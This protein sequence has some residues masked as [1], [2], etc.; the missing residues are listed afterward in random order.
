MSDSMPFQQVPG[1]VE[2][3]DL[4]PMSGWVVHDVAGKPQ[5]TQNQTYWAWCRVEA[6]QPGYVE[7]HFTEP[8]GSTPADPYPPA[9][10]GTRRPVRLGPVLFKV[11]C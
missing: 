11:F 8:D 10:D 9:P 3:L 1:E 7:I 6:N 4:P 2:T 5:S